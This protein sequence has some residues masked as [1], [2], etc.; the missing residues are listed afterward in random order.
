MSLRRA[1]GDWARGRQSPARVD[2]LVSRSPVGTCGSA[3]PSPSARGGVG[4]RVGCGWMTGLP[5]VGSF[6]SCARGCELA[7]V[8][9][10]R[11][12]RR[13]VTAWRRLRDWAEAGHECRTGRRCAGF[14][15]VLRTGTQWD[16]LPQGRGLD[17]V[18]SVARTV[19]W[20]CHRPDALLADCGYEDGKYRRL[21]WQRGI[22]PVIAGRGQPHGFGLDIFRYVVGRTIAWLRLPPPAHPLGATC[23]HP[24]KLPRA[25][26]LPHHLQT[27]PF[28]CLDLLPGHRLWHGD[29]V[30]DRPSRT[31][32]Q[33]SSCAAAR[34]R[35][36]CNW[37]LRRE[38]SK[39]S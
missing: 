27:R 18:P 7:D 31:R 29:G 9:T 25:R 12:G 39:L 19:G 35:R 37:R 16:Y 2:G 6:T 28:L 23:P 33:W 26:H 17:R 8:H 36:C 10:E 32:A 15:F 3:A 21:L 30:A 14:L 20:P 13:G 11:V 5:C 1:L 4:I 24:R 22:R 38:G 34:R